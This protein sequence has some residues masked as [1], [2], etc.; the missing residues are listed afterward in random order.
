MR[1]FLIIVSAVI[2][3]LFVGSFVYKDDSEN[4]VANESVYE[5]V[6]R[7]GKIRCGYY[8]Y[9][10][11]LLKDE[12]TGQITGLIH[13]TV[14]EA[15]HVLNLE[16][17]WVEEVS[18]SDAVT[19]LQNR[20]YDMVCAGFYERPNVMKQV[21]FVGPLYY[22]TVNAY[23]RPDDNRFDNDVSKIND[24]AYT[25]SSVD[26]SIP[27]IIARESFANAKSFSLPELAPYSDNMLNVDTGKADVTFVENSVANEYLRNNPDTLKKLHPPVR[28]FPVTLHVNKDEMAFKT[29]MD[30]AVRH[31][32]NNGQMEKIIQKYEVQSGDYLR[33][34][35]P[36]MLGE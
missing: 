17:E 1:T 6:M 36:F 15:A 20:R 34:S 8:Y 14:E 2:L 30:S 35:K 16:V 11:A 4:S 3:S 32:H 26:G 25:I 13:D 10:P 5:R 31:L 7:T 21:E 12:K 23:V 22:I 9:S 27:D 19:G 33:V 24:P 18:I 29:M 28:T